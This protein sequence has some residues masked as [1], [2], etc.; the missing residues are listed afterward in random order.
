MSDAALVLSL[1]PGI[2]LLDLA[3]DKEGFCVVRGPDP[4]FGGD[5]QDFHPPAGR[6]D[7]VIGGPP[8][9]AFTPLSNIDDSIRAGYGNLVP[10][11]ERC[12]GE[13]QPAWFLMEN[14]RQAPV[15]NVPGYEVHVQILNNRWLGEEQN[16]VRLIA[17][18]TRDGR[19]L[20]IQTEALENPVWAACVTSANGGERRTHF[21]KA[22]GGRVQRYSVE[23]ALRLQGLPESFFNKF[24]PRSPFTRQGQLKLLANGVP[25]PMGRAVARAVRET[26]EHDVEHATHTAVNDQRTPCRMS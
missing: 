4:L 8:C 13:A 22:T 2:G 26:L 9:Q 11:F 6:F 7:G 24:K 20:R 5:V 14:V 1:F 15:P 21:A 10:E 16:R 19:R 25:L 23:E 17:F 18:G 3:F 12:V